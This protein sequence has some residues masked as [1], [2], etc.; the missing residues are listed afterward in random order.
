MTIRRRTAEMAAEQAR[1]IAALE[2]TGDTRVAGRLR[3]CM[4]AMSSRRLGDG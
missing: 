3:R 1:V 2:A 4:E